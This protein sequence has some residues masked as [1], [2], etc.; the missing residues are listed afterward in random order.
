MIANVNSYRWKAAFMPT[1]ARTSLAE[2]VAAGRA[3]LARDGLAALTMQRV[4]EQVGVRA[5]SLYRRVPSRAA[6]VR[7]VAADVIADVEKRLEAAASTGDA[8]LDLRALARAFRAFAV[9]DPHSF[10]LLFA[11]LPEGSSPDP[12]SFA[13]AAVPVLRVAGQLAGPEHALSAART[14]TSWASGFLRME[15]AGSFQLGGSVEEAFDFGVELLA[16]GLGRSSEQG[17]R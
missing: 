12:A 15:L 6:L 13:A 1:P 14:I 5:P 3:I 2:I 7:L 9:A 16:H 8:Q 17:P 10:G 11:P 4:G